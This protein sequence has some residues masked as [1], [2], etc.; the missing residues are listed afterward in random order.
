MKER[1][2]ENVVGRGILKG[3]APSF[4]VSLQN[5]LAPQPPKVKYVCASDQLILE[6]AMQR[7]VLR[8]KNSKNSPTEDLVTGV[9]VGLKGRKLGKGEFQVEDICYSELPPPGA[10]PGGGVSEDKCVLSSRKHRLLNLLL[11]DKVRLAGVRTEPGVLL[12]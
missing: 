9:V 12:V 3:P 8:W 11:F 1:K 10:C 7:V 5:H 2:Q 6:D 4:P